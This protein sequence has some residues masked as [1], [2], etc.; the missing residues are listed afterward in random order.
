MKNANEYWEDGK[1]FIEKTKSCKCFEKI[2]NSHVLT[3]KIIQRGEHEYVYDIGADFLTK[4]YG[5]KK[6]WLTGSAK[7]SALSA[8]QRMDSMIEKAQI[9][10]P[11]FQDSEKF[12]VYYE[13][14]F[15]G[16]Y[17]C[18]LA[19]ADKENVRCFV[20][21][22]YADIGDIIHKAAWSPIDETVAELL[23]NS[24]A[25]TIEKNPFYIAAVQK[26][27]ELLQK[28][29]KAYYRIATDKECSRLSKL[30]GRKILPSLP[31]SFDKAYVVDS[32]TISLRVLRDSGYVILHRPCFAMMGGTHSK[33]QLNPHTKT[34]LD[35]APADAESVSFGDYVGMI[36][37]YQHGS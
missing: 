17:D 32:D 5:T 9:S 10:G 6:L 36:E 14:K 28:Q 23:R 26:G 29:L 4:R 7:A 2:G 18:L 1:L 16:R 35:A 24:K 25:D 15:S 30:L 22:E 34:G 13:R 31:E 20:C 21:F 19:F 3:C 11:G 8:A 37:S 12:A 33:W 27:D